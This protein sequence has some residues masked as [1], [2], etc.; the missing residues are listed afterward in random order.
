ME[1]LKHWLEGERRHATQDFALG[2]PLFLE[3]LKATERV[4]VPLDT[5]LAAGRAD[6]ERN[7]QALRDA[8]AQYLPGGALRPA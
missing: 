6:L 3:M 8:C 7:T 4:D 5:L 2:A 1:G